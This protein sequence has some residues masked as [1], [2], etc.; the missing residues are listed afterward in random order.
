MAILSDPLAAA[1]GATVACVLLTSLARRVAPPLGFVDAPDGGRK[2]HAEPT[3]LL[4]GAAVVLTVVLGSLLL[5][6][7]PLEGWTARTPLL[8]SLSLVCVVGLFDDRFGMRPR[9]KLLGIAAASVPYALV[10]PEVAEVAVFHWVVPLGWL[11]LPFALFWLVACANIVNLIDGLDGLA[12]GVGLAAAATLALLA[13]HRGDPGSLWVAAL[14]AGAL[15]GFLVHNWPPARI[16]LGDAGSLSIGFLVGALALETAQK[17][18]AG[19]ALVVPVVLLAIPV[20]DTAMA[21]LR[22]KLGGRDISQADHRHLHHRLQARG[23][24]REQSLVA[25]LVLCAAGCGAAIASERLDSDWPAVLVCGCVFSSLVWARVFGDEETNLLVQHLRA[26]GDAVSQSTR[27]L[28][29][30]FLMV[31]LQ[32]QAREAGDAP[33]ASGDSPTTWPDL[34]ERLQPLGVRSVAVRRDAEATFERIAPSTGSACEPVPASR[35]IGGSESPSVWQLRVA[36]GTDGVELELSGD[37]HDA[38]LDEIL[39]A[40]RYWSQKNAQPP[41]HAA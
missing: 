28:R 12:T 24:S 17:R 38:R 6:L 36:P 1:T 20:F 2:R 9:T 39:L 21:I 15:T 4:G 35:P 5:S 14:L 7:G 23:L 29:L 13:G 19:F 32:A 30:R 27:S 41:S 40:V 18:T 22:R 16:F 37:A 31:Q 34:I 33:A 26:V 3:P 8:A 11:S 25:I 10:A